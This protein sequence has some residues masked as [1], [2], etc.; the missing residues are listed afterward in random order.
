MVVVLWVPDPPNIHLDGRKLIL[1]R[2]QMAQKGAPCQLHQL[3]PQ[4]GTWKVPETCKEPILERV[5]YRYG[6]P[7]S[8]RSQ[9]HAHAISSSNL[10]Y[11]LA[12]LASPSL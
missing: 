10:R 12:A 6:P 1:P 11:Q 4:T 9:S 7:V 8:L 5:P 2:Q 3:C